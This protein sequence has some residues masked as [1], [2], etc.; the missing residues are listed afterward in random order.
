VIGEPFAR[1]LAG[2]ASF[3]ENQQMFLDRNGYL[4]ETFFTC[5]G[6]GGARPRKETFF[7][8]ISHEFRTPLSLILGPTEEAL[9]SPERALRDED[10][11]V[12]YRNELRLVKLV[13]TLLDFSRLE[14]GR[15][16]AS[17]EPTD[18]ASATIELAS[19]FRSAV[20]KAGLTLTV[21]CPTLPEPIYVDRE[22]WEKIVLNLLSNAFKFTFEGG[23]HA[24]LRWLGDRVELTVRD[25]GVGIPPS[26]L[27]HVFERFHRVRGTRAR[28]H[29]GTGIGL[30]LVQELA[31]LHGGKAHA[32]SIEQQGTTITVAVKT[33]TLHLPANRISAERT[34]EST[35]LGAAPFVEEAMD[36]Y[37]P[38]LAAFRWW[39][40]R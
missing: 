12:V 37:R 16:Q 38:V 20:E 6:A 39:T 8:N 10:L 15:L 26:E 9:R 31:R 11:D 21:D 14:A 34:L 13:N 40:A 32:E 33:G 24:T 17:Y 35:G 1:A 22:M 25:S 3:I 2:H 23:I 19:V 27:P 28:T 29:E 36:G 18:L 7:S 30:A 4:E 5:R